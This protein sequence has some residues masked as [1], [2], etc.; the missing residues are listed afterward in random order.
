MGPKVDTAV[1]HARDNAPW[2]DCGDP[3]HAGF[4]ALFVWPAAGGAVTLTFDGRGRRH[5][6]TLFN[7]RDLGPEIVLHGR[8]FSV[9]PAEPGQ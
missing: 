6:A 8:R 1:P 2:I 5:A 9:S 3:R 4:G 7:R